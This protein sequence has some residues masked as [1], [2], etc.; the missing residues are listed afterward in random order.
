M[1]KQRKLAARRRNDT[2]SVRPVETPSTA[3]VKECAQLDYPRYV[4]MIQRADPEEELGPD[5]QSEPMTEKQ[6]AE[7]C[8]NF[9][10]MRNQFRR[11]IKTAFRDNQDWE[12]VYLVVRAV[13]SRRLVWSLEPN[14]PAFED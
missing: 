13:T 1:K 6:D 14:D 7:A 4:W 8:R 2:Y 9:A 12:C 11:Q 5:C 3:P 10:T